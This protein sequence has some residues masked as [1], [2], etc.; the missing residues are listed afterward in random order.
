MAKIQKITS[1]QQVTDGRMGLKKHKKI[2]GLLPSG[3]KTSRYRDD[4]NTVNDY[5]CNMLKPGENIL[6]LKPS[7]WTLP[8]GDLKSDYYFKN[9][10]HL[11]EGGYRLFSGYIRNILCLKPTSHHFSSIACTYKIYFHR[12]TC[13]C[14]S[15]DCNNFAFS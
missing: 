12:C 14:S 9:G 13:H 5:L 4:V 1:S 3:L 7:G 10:L 6:Y 2:S 15:G 11:I 8:N